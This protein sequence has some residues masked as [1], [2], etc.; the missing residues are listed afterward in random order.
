M[1]LVMSSFATECTESEFLQ[2]SLKPGS[3]AS[4]YPDARKQHKQIR[5][6]SA[7]DKPKQETDGAGVYSLAPA[8]T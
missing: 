2:E 3:M 8:F 1:N 4:V 5:P 7:S 6:D